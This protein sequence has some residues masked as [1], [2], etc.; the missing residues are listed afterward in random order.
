MR[1]IPFAIRAQDAIGSRR[2][3][4]EELHT[5]RVGQREMTM[6]FEHRDQLRQE[7]HEAL[8]ADAIGRRPRDD[9]RVLHR[10]TI[11]ALTRSGQRHRYGNGMGE[12]PDSILAR[13]A[14]DGDELIE[15]D[16]LLRRRRA[17]ITGRDTRE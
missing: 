7:G 2:T 3:E 14:G 5:H 10:A 4:R 15:D 8:G 17:L 1:R 13:V 11:E 9:E 12:E 16:R 6:P